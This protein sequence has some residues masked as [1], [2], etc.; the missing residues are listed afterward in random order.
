MKKT[1][2]FLSLLTW[3]LFGFAESRVW[4]S[5]LE[6]KP[7]EH[8]FLRINY[9]FDEGHIISNYQLKVNLPEG[10]TVDGTDVVLGSCHTA[11]TGSIVNNVLVVTSMNVVLQGTSGVLVE[12]PVV[13][14]NNLT[15]GDELEVTLENV[16]LGQ[17]NQTS[18]NSTGIEADV[19]IVDYT[20]LDENAITVPAAS[21]T[22]KKVKV[23]RT[24]KG[25]EW[26][27]ICLP[28]DMSEQQVKDVF[29]ADVQIAE[30]DSYS[31]ET[32]GSNVTGITIN[33]EE[34]DLSDGF[35]GNTPYVIKTSEDISEFTLT[36][37]VAPADEIEATYSNGSGPN[38]KTGKFIGTYQAETAVPENALFLSGNKFY[39]SAGKTRMKGFRGYFTFN[40]VLTEASSAN[41]RIQMAFD[42][43]TDVKELKSSRI[44]GLKSCYNLK[45]QRVEKPVKKGVYI[46]DGKK[47]VVK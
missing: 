45:G 43:T 47:V 26:S 39:Y 12:I 34:V 13:A 16:K 25:G 2:L 15:V 33:F 1:V 9:E 3:V 19:E 40:K 42:E 24:I 18:I 31:V 37:T 8:S 20:L 14:D 46:R 7:G 4:V 32:E 27:T 23:K 38:K 22:D 35:W 21:A 44:E 5:P 36:T 10:V 29:G 6:I 41:A 30:F 28:F 17:T 11:H